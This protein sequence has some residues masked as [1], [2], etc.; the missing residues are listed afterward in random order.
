[1]IRRAA[2]TLLAAALL[3]LTGCL[4]EEITLTLEADGRGTIQIERVLRG[5]RPLAPPGAELS[6]E[7]VATAGAGVLAG[8]HG[9]ATWTDV[10]V[11]QTE[12]G[13]LRLAATGWFTDVR[14]LGEA[15]DMYGPGLELS[16]DDSG[17]EWV[18][19][20]REVAA[21]DGS[22]GI[23][24]LSDADFARERKQAMGEIARLTTGLRQELTIVTPHEVVEVE[25]GEVAG[26]RRVTWSRDAEALTGL[27][28]GAMDHVAELRPVVATGELTASEAQARVFADLQEE[29]TLTVSFTAPVVDEEAAA[30]FDERL[31]AAREAFE[32]SPWYDRLEGVRPGAAGGPGARRRANE[33]AAIGALRTLVTAQSVFREADK[34][35]DG[36]FDYASSMAELGKVALIDEVLAGG[37]K[38]GYTFNLHASPDAPEFLWMAT[39][40]PVEPDAGGRSFVVNHEGVVYAIDEPADLTTDC[41]IPEG[42]VPAGR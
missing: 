17:D 25:G 20:R 18:L 32:A 33:A 30:T 28:E 4:E 38:F 27:L 5:P 2:P 26:G 3:G 31:E 37:A 13:A 42:A 7:D 11:E 12:D 39:A 14:E 15:E 36:V 23:F 34:E 22:P 1:V 6:A 19:R 24:E 9:V 29:A 35:G 41:E 40:R 21:N 10:E 16:V 8:F